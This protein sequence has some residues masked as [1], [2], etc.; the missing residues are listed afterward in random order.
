MEQMGQLVVLVGMVQPEQV[1]ILVELV[2][3]VV[4]LV[5]VVLLIPVG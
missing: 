2:V 1:T 3:L 5:P 4:Q